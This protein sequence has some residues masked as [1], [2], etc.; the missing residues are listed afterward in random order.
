MSRSDSGKFLTLIVTVWPGTMFLFGTSL[1]LGS[2]MWTDG[3]R[4]TA[5]AAPAPG[6]DAAIIAPTVASDNTEVATILLILNELA[7]FGNLTRG[8]RWPH[9][10]PT[11]PRVPARPT[12]VAATSR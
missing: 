9:R 2:A 8:R 12:R 1:A 10:S 7:P 4:W 3:A 6:V 5:G 11:L